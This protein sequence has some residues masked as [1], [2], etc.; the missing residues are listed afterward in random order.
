MK[1]GIIAP[2]FF[3][4]SMITLQIHGQETTYLSSDQTVNEGVEFHNKGEYDKAIA[5][6]QKV[7]KCDPNYDWA[8]YEM[9]LTYYYIDKYEEAL[10]KCKEALT[11]N[12]DKAYVYS[13]MGTILDETGRQSEGIDLLNAALKKW[14]YNQNILYNLAVCY[15]NTD[16]PLLAEDILIKSLLINP[17]HTRTHLALAKANYLMGRIA[18]SYLAYS[19]VLLL[20]PSVNN[21]GAFEE[22]ISQKP[23]LKTQE[24]KYPYAKNV[25]AEKWNEIKG[26]LQSE[27]AFSKEFEYEYDYNYTSG[28]QSLML[29]Q[30]LTFDP[31][32]TSIYSRFYARLFAEIYQKVGFETYLNYILK[33]INNENVT[34]WSAKNKAKLDSFIEWAQTYLNQGRS[35]GFSYMDEKNAKQTFH[36][37]EKGNLV[38]IG[39][40]SL[41]GDSIKNGTWLI[42]GDG[43]YI[44]EKGAYINDREEGEWIEY[45][46]DGTIVNRLNFLKGK[47]D[48]TNKSFYPNG[49]IEKNYNTKSGKREGIFETYTSSGFI[50]GKNSYSE[51][52]VNGPGFFN[53]YNG[54]FKR[55]YYYSKGN[56][57]KENNETWVNGNAKQHAVYSNGML[58]GINNTWYSNS[59][60]ESERN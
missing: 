44:S 13:L 20:N 30:K 8:C 7:S 11:I 2:L 1:K 17:Y 3:I 56:L 53:D 50:S 34:K 24:Y 40:L 59:R 48:G 26:L 47:L 35:Y 57:E 16:K 37:D 18:Q 31:S 36:Y 41:N 32:D 45:R 60:K 6:Y 33:N 19:M 5:S 22:A 51:G 4:F 12:Y 23:K 10:A 21:L 27:L 14:P 42:I 25:N 49:A 54:G 9:A 39:E 55:E 52:L 15:I 58:N 28:R 38:S 43:G 29:L 46:P